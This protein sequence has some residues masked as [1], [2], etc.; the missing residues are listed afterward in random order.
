MV[1]HT[2]EREYKDMAINE[3]LPNRPITIK[4][5]TDENIFL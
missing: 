4:Y 3:L 1:G 5:I 2:S